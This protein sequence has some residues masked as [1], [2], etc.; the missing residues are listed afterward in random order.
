MEEC[1]VPA[2]LVA[3]VMLTTITNGRNNILQWKRLVRVLDNEI[4]QYFFFTY[5]PHMLVVQI[6]FVQSWMLPTKG[7]LNYY[8]FRLVN[9]NQT[10]DRNGQT[11]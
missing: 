3:P 8:N 6:C 7:S 5:G 9:E 2:P 1:E 11:F 4:R 10:W